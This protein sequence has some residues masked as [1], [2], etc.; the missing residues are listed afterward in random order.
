MAIRIPLL[1]EGDERVLSQ[2]D[3]GVRHNMHAR[4]DN[5][6]G[7]R[8]AVGEINLLRQMLS[9]VVPWEITIKNVKRE[10]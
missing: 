5:L 3:S 2:P 1:Q 9:G 4:S 8:I 10:F 6:S 7:I